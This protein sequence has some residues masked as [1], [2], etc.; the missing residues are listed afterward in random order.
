MRLEPGFTWILLHVTLV[1]DPEDAL[2][3]PCGFGMQA[4][5]SNAQL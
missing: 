5:H 4:K 2:A 1:E 3:K